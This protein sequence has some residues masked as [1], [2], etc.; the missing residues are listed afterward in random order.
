MASTAAVSTVPLRELHGRRAGGGVAVLGQSLDVVALNGL[1][2]V[3]ERERE[4][5]GS[6]E[7]LEEQRNT[8]ASS[9][10]TQSRVSWHGSLLS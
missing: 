10:W 9:S 8:F 1:D 2:W 4:Y 5:D 7:G 3:H 6:A